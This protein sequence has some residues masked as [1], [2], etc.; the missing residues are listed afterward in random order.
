MMLKAAFRKVRIT[1]EEPAPLQGYDPNVHIAESESD[2]LDDLYARVIVLENGGS[3]KVIVSVDCC[4]TNEQTFQASDPG[5]KVGTYRHLLQTFPVGTRRQWAESA[6]VQEES[7]S[8]HATH[9]HSAP[10]HFG[11]KYTARIAQAISEAAS[12]LQPVRIR[13]ASGSNMIAVNRRPH[14]QHNEEL[15]VDRALNVAVFEDEEGKLIGALVNCAVHPT[16][17]TN[18]L[19]RV[20]SEFVGLAMSEWEER[21]GH[22]FTALFI[23]GFLGDV[24]PYGHYRNEESDTY[25]WVKRIAHELFQQIMEAVKQ[26]VPVGGMPLYSLERTVELPTRKGYF[27]P[28]IPVVL[29]GNRIGDL[30]ILSVSCEVFNGYVNILQAESP[31]PS[32]WFSAVANGY[33]GYLPTSSAYRDGLGGYEMN[34][35]PYSEEASGIFVQAAKQFLQELT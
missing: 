12:H 11:A 20:S 1:P 17:L 27:L 31:F 7:V 24:G 5:G 9:T 30:V 34:T 10:E 32:T 13:A 26:S 23:Q 2:I 28:S 33:C 16:L 3:R 6:G 22:G 4:L 25:P 21:E 15:P 18:P 35:T 8:V 29:H 19:N 14:L